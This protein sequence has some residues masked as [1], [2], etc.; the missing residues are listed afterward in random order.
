MTMVFLKAL[1]AMINEIVIM[2]ISIT[3]LRKIYGFYV[4]FIYG[5][6]Q[7]RGEQGDRLSS[8]SGKRNW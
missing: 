8:K 2:A 3:K 1:L 5:N 6:V 4:I 7:E